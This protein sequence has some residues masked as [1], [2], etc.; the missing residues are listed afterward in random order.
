MSNFR[1]LRSEF[2]SLYE[3]AVSAEK[4]V[5]SDPRSSCFRTRH[6]LELAVHWLYDYDRG[7]RRPY[8][9]SL[10]ALLTQ[11]D[12]EQLLPPPVY[13]KARLIQ[14]L[15]NQA[16]HSSRPV[17]AFDA[18][19]LCRELFH[20][21][22][23][24][25]R[26][27]TRKSDPK[28]LEAV[29]DE[30]LIPRLVS[31]EQAVTLAREALK[32]QEEEFA[33]KLAEERAGLDGREAAIAE[34]ARSLDEQEAALAGVNAELVRVR[35][36]L[37][38]AKQKNLKVPDT[39]DYNE[40]QTRKLLIDVLLAE[41]GWTAGANASVEYPVSGMPNEKGEGFV[42]YVLW[43]QD[44]LPLAVVE[45]KRTL[46]DADVGQQ[47]ALLYANCLE[48]E[49]GQRP[50]I[51]YTNGYKIWLWD[52]CR[53]GP[54]EVQGFYTR[55]EL[56]LAVQRRT[57]AENPLDRPARNSIV[58]RYYQKRAIASLCEAFN[59][60][61]RRGLLAL[62]TGTGKTR[63]AIALA[64][65]LMRAN[66]V[67]RVLFLADRIALVNQAANAFKAHL[68]EATTVNLVT[69]KDKL[70]RVY[71][72]TYPTM[73]GL[74]D[75][76]QAAEGGEIRRF[77]V[78][79][80]DLVIIDEAHRSVYQ[81]YG[82]IFDYFDSLLVGLTA[83]PRDEVHRDT[84]DLFGLE[85]G[86]PTDAYTL[87]DAVKDGYLVPP[88]AQSVPLKFVREGIKY[89][90][91][92][93]EEKEHWESLDWGEQVGED[94]INGVPGGVDASQVNKWLFN[95]DTVDRMLR[96]LM[97][98]GLKVDGGDRLGKT[99]IFARNN[100][101]ARFIAERFD[102]H[103]PQY[104]G[105]F[106]RMITFRVNYAQTLIDDFSIA[107]RAPHIAISVDM[108]DTGID[109]PDV[110]NLVFFKPVRSKVK[111]LQMIGRGTRLREDL[112]G[113]GQHKCEFLI[114]DYCGNFEFFNEQ[115]DGREASA[116]EPLGKRLFRQRLELLAWLGR[117]ESE[118][119]AVADI[120]AP[121]HGNIESEAELRSALTHTLL[122]EVQAM[123]VD[124]FIVRPQRE[125]VER[126]GQP[127]NWQMLDDEA[128][129][130]LVHHVAGL[131]STHEGEHITARLFDLTCL[132]LQL[133]LIER[134]T[135]LIE[136]LINR[137]RELA[138][139]LEAAGNVP[140]VKAQLELIHAV[141]EEEFWKGIT[142][143]M[144]EN[145]RRRLRGLIQFIDKTRSKPVYSA[146]DDEMGEVTEV[147]LSSFQTGVNMAQYR[148]KVE[149]FIR[150]N[151]NH[152]AIAKLKHDRPL[153]PQDLEELERF[154]YESGEVGGRERFE[155]CFGTEQPLTLFIRSLVGLDR[156]AAKEAFAEIMA[157]TQLNSRQ[158]RFVEMIIDHLTR[159]GSMKPGQLYEPPFTSLHYEGLDGLFPGDAAEKVVR[160]VR[161]INR[162]AEGSEE[163]A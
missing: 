3:P 142:L 117:Q 107:T 81:K 37:A 43:G 60:G 158:I 83:T 94:I 65:V 50:V 8:D 122:S 18:L 51:F 100:D 141:Q 52:D 156:A 136:K 128:M 159:Q 110:V 85:K 63:I 109:V 126:F 96:Y 163:A 127:E 125:H 16:V 87:E 121:P 2:A 155:A 77:G 131:P 135:A 7:L 69:E 143:P 90:E 99:I 92:S 112:F 40:L 93:E 119:L 134:M 26:T 33:Q 55:E 15:G 74:I 21:L 56:S 123:N 38:E 10:N 146:L 115:P 139:A 39:H 86:V 61:Q 72:S 19:R 130:V 6:A 152:V 80:F 59:A 46:K 78:G 144:V 133:A 28:T 118:T 1:F 105:A 132:N 34:Q 150:A 79:H 45:A 104:K 32:K 154:V 160:I 47:Q 91:L 147:S 57:I 70:G 153:T 41:A 42:D 151:E 106:A 95:E 30:A 97:D 89:D 4:L 11:S 13:Q 12:F 17:Q 84:Y 101:H 145:L 49:K 27:Y 113:P 73:M 36:E 9:R 23:W 58:E 149:A 138:S 148:K 5:H 35:A 71:V 157:D 114:F 20:L 161:S 29:F 111:F 82:A 129:G 98:H 22:F 103:Y 25:A 48:Q 116:P 75:K 124:N 53:A 62:A 31:S 140:A 54:R 64:D 137:I 120:N 108:L 68:P 67:K 88:R 76:G 66:W 14:K 162:R 24:L 44:G 102:H